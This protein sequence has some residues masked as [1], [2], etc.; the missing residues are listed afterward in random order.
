MSAAS[1]MTAG[2]Y[3]YICDLVRAQSALTLEPG[4][5]YLVESRLNPLARHR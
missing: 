5:E 1:V 3:G 4:K 2:D